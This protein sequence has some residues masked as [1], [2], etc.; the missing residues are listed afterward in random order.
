MLTKRHGG[1]VNSTVS[2][3]DGGQKSI[4]HYNALLQTGWSR[5]QNPGGTKIFFSIPVQTSPGA[6]QS[7]STMGTGFLYL[8]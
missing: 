4:S 8:G 3:N 1:E 7:F 2:Y 5:V 6:Q